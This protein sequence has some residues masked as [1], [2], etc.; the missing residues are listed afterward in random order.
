MICE[1]CG[2]SE[3]VEEFVTEVFEVDGKR[4]LV[5]QIPAQVCVQCGETI[6]S[7]ETAEKI[8]LMVH[9]AAEPI[10]VTQ[11]ETFTFV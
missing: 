3:V 11:L 10:G 1:V 6:F 2:C 8:R 7:R 9:G 4:V 5:E